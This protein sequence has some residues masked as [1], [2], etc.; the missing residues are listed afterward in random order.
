MKF[1]AK[2]STA[3]LAFG[4]LS[5]ACAGSDAKEIGGN[6]YCSAVDQLQYSNVGTAGT[7][8]QITYMGADGSCESNPKAFS[9][10]LSPLDEEVSPM[11]L[12]FSFTRYFP[13]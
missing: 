2:I 8:N 11:P 12:P 7:Y 10:P 4:G 6:W 1:T 3:L 13:Y 5:A 9:G